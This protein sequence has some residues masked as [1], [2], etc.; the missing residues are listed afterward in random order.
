M[1]EGP[2]SFLQR[3]IFPAQP[4]EQHHTVAMLL[5]LK[6]LQPRNRAICLD[7]RGITILKKKNKH[8]RHVE[9]KLNTSF[10]TNPCSV[11]QPCLALTVSRIPPQKILRGK[12]CC[13]ASDSC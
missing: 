4:V 7:N 9:N 13:E 1:L 11:F 8:K 2:M 5:I 3:Q 12:V 6:L 10:V